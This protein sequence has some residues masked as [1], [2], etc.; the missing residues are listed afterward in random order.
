MS[1]AYSCTDVPVNRRYTSPRPFLHLGKP[2]HAHP[3]AC[4]QLTYLIIWHHFRKTNPSINH[5]D[6]NNSTRN[7]DKG[8]YHRDTNN[9]AR[10]NNKGYHHRDTNNSTRNNS[11]GYYH[12][13]TNNSTRNNN[14]GYYHRDTN[15]ANDI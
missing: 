1:K 3:S 9:S 14:K 8:D 4:L 12:R 5:R 15:N 10:N 11:K 13:D 7:N 6:T 2:F